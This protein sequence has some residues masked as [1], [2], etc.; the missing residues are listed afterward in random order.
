MKTRAKEL[1]N[2]ELLKI[3][4]TTSRNDFDNSLS[5]IANLADILDQTGDESGANKMDDILKQAGFWSSLFSGMAGGGGAAIWEAFKSGKFKESLT[6]IV[7]KALMAGTAAVVVDYIIKWLDE[8]PVIGSILKELEGADKLRSILEGVIGAAVAESDLANKL[9][10]QTILAVEKL[11]GFGP[12]AKKPEPAKQEQ[13]A[14]VL[15]LKPK[16]APVPAEKDDNG[17]TAH[18]QLAAKLKND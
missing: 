1:F 18:F 4:F 15:P 5:K 8:V 14:N 9:V 12:G 11:I 10:D 13:A 2:K 7:K 3:L 17:D 16:A 6:E